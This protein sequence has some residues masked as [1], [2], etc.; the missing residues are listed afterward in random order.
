MSTDRIHTQTSGVPSFTPPAQGVLAY[1]PATGVL[2]INRDGTLGGWGTGIGAGASATTSFTNGEAF[3]ITKG[4][5]VYISGTNTVKVVDNTSEAASRLIAI[6][7]EDVLTASSGAFFTL[8]GTVIQTVQLITGLGAVA[9]GDTLYVDTAGDFTTVAPTGAG[10]YLK[11][12]L[13][14]V[15]GTA[16]VGTVKADSQVVAALAQE[17]ASLNA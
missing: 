8:F 17:A 13:I 5:G 4:Q 3:T 14:V 7:A 1:D 10:L 11:V 6:A 16:Y 12:G 2:Y 15:D 9:A